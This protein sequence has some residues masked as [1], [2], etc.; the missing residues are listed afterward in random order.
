[1]SHIDGYDDLLALRGRNFRPDTAVLITDSDVIEYQ[2]REV[3]WDRF[4]SFKARVTGPVGGCTALRIRNEKPHNLVAL[5]GLEVIALLTRK[6]SRPWLEMIRLA[7][8]ADLVEV[9]GP[10]AYR[11]ARAIAH[12]FLMDWLETA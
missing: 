6:T 2:W 7:K 1:M 10:E 12:R 4:P 5:R 8:P 3:L 11:T 9:T